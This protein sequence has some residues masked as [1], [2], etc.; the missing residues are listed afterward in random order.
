[1]S[2]ETRNQQM[3][4]RE[5]DLINQRLTWLLTSQALLFAALGLLFEKGDSGGG[6][7]PEVAKII[8]W[9]PI[10]GFFSTVFILLGIV[11]AMWAQF[12][13]WKRWRDSSMYVSW[14]CVVIGWIAAGGLCAVFSIAWI[15]MIMR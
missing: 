2:N 14:T 12:S 15:A 4:Q 1:M 8:K 10:L 9:I 5:D 6:G 13:L 3:W 11:G 7:V